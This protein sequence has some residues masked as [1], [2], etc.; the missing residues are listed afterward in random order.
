MVAFYIIFKYIG[1]YAQT[2]PK[3]SLKKE[4][5]KKAKSDIIVAALKPVVK[6]TSSL[7]GNITGTK[8]KKKK[9]TVAA[10]FRV[11]R[12]TPIQQLF[13]FGLTYDQVTNNPYNTNFLHI[14]NSIKIVHSSFQLVLSPF[15]SNREV[16]S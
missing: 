8:K 4:E 7:H 13:L 14:S 6:F 11:G 9:S 3:V 1:P 12:V 2:E 10:F 5:K 16:N 15:Y